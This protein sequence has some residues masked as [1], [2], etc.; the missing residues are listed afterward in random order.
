MEGV[1]Y[2]IARN[3][4]V[5]EARR[6]GKWL[7]YQIGRRYCAAGCGVPEHGHGRFFELTVVTGGRGTATSAGVEVALTAGDVH[8]SFPGDVHAI[9]S[10]EGEP[11]RYDFLT[12]WAAGEDGEISSAV[13]Y[14]CRAGVRLVRDGRISRLVTYAIDEVMQEGDGDTEVIEHILGLIFAYLCRTVRADGERKMTEAG[15]AESLCYGAMSYI[16]RNIYAIR[17]LAEVAQALSYNYSYLSLVFKRTTGRTLMEYYTERRLATADALL[18]SGVSVT[19]VAS[20]LGYSSPYTLSR[21]YSNRFGYP[22][23]HAKA[24]GFVG[25]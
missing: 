12:F 18:R 24:Q 13:D 9:C 15:E 25:V 4:I 20:R 8:L 21:A 3:Y 2:I 19:E 10:D 17:S 22:P 6:V 11:L 1:K 7:L 5:N 16:D 14:C 23:S